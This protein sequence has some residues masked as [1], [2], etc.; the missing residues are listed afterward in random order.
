M[1]EPLKGVASACTSLNAIERAKARLPFHTRRRRRSRRI[2]SR[3]FSSFSSSSSSSNEAKT[4]AT[5]PVVNV[6]E[7]DKI[8]IENIARDFRRSFTLAK[9]KEDNEEEEEEEEETSPIS[10][11]K[12]RR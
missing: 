10:K 8:I 9:K 3:S 5:P 2:S 1:V 4:E 12:A 6:V 11:L 7:R